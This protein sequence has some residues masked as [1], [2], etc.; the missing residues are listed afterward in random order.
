MSDDNKDYGFE[1]LP[2][3]E[4]VDQVDC[5][6]EDGIAYMSVHTI[7]TMNSTIAHVVDDMHQAGI[8][9]FEEE[10]MNV[11]I[12]VMTMWQGLHDALDLEAAKRSIPDTPE[13]LLTDE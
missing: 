1:P 2:F 6:Y 13:E 4:V 9:D 11:L 7:D 10:T 8:V 12:W 5:K 3:E